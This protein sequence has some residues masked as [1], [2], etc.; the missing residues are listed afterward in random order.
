ME[1]ELSERLANAEDVILA[2]DSFKKALK[3][4]WTEKLYNF[5]YLSVEKV[6]VTVQVLAIILG[7]AFFLMGY[8]GIYT[9]LWWEGI[10]V[11]FA[12]YVYARLLCSRK[13]FR[14]FFPDDVSKELEV[15]VGTFT[16]T[17]RRMS[18]DQMDSFLVRQ[19]KDSE[20][21]E[22]L[23]ILSEFVKYLFA[24]MPDRKSAIITL[25]ELS[26]VMENIELDIAR[27]M[28]DAAAKLL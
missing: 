9:M 8:L 25:E 10:I 18:K 20:N 13:A 3:L 17:F 24:V 1:K 28:R 4:F 27:M 19:V 26:E 15:V 11:A 12:M 7:I 6:R 2:K 14:K 22:L 23:P 5:K 21:Q 16:P